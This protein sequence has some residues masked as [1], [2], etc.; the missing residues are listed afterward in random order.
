MSIEGVRVVRGYG[1]YRGAEPNRTPNPVRPNPNRTRT[2]PRNQSGCTML[3]GSGV[4]RC[5]IGA[6]VVMGCIRTI[7]DAAK[8]LIAEI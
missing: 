2:E 1:P 6:N 7:G 4:S 8:P 3:K 5:V